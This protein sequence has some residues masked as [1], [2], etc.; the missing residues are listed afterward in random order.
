[1]QLLHIAAKRAK[2]GADTND[3]GGSAARPSKSRRGGGTDLKEDGEAVLTAGGRCL[4]EREAR[5]VE[6]RHEVGD[7]YGLIVDN[8]L[9][10][11]WR[12]QLTQPLGSCNGDLPRE[13]SRR[14]K[15]SL[16]GFLREARPARERKGKQLFFFFSSSTRWSQSL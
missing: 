13:P 15:T 12:V 10:V 2:T 9:Q 11:K 6:G 4:P 8:E 14:L 7:S 3:D 5:L 16:T 1:M